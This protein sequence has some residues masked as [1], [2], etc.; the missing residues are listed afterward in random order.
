M[1]VTAYTGRYRAI[2]LTVPDVMIPG[3]VPPSL[4]PVVLRGYAYVVAVMDPTTG[5]CVGFADRDCV[6]SPTTTLD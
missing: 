5:F 3:P 2:S 4:T 1:L 6:N